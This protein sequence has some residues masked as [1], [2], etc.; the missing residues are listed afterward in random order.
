MKSA[1]ETLSPTRV[2]LIVEV[3]FDELKPDLDAAYQTIGSQIQ[4]P[5]FRK[6]KVPARIIDQR[7]GRGAVVQEAVNEALP[8]FFSQ[9]VDAEGIKAIGQPEVDVTAVPLEDGQ[10]FEFTVETDVRPEIELPE[11]DGIAVEVDE[12]KASD[13]D[14]EERLTSLRQRFGTLTAVERAVEDGDVLSID[15]KAEID[16]D[17]ID[18]VEG[19]TYEVGSGNM[20]DGLDE[21]VLG[22]TAGDSRS[23]SSPLAGGDRE[24]EVA[25]CTVT[26]QSVKVRELPELDDDFAQ[27]A[28]QFDTLD[29][30]REDV[31]KQAEQAKKFEQGVQAR[32]KVLEHLLEVTEVAVPD[33][34]VEAEV[35]S[36][37]EG[38]GRLEDDEH[39]AEV[40]ESTRKALKGQFLL[41]A[42]AEKLEIEV[43]Q[44]ELIEYLIMSAQ[45]YGMDPNQFAQ[46]IDQQGQV[47]SMVQEVARRKALAAVLE[48][49]VVTDTA[50]TT[51]DLNELVPQADVVDP[52]LEDE[53]DL[54]ALADEVETDAEAADEAADAAEE[55]T[56]A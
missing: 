45:Q 21:A 3:P 33:G 37:L 36:H 12:V 14:I 54:E 23:F 47:P 6:G 11:L 17:E 43:E 48:K 26:V 56:K 42:L 32:D 7:V 38:E 44:P 55:P 27:L 4:I 16:G 5:G 9:A 10:D 8:R 30:L 52:E 25:E 19:V 20:L 41:D 1:V 39:R 35:H 46:A 53:A 24:G 18:S 15:L 51:I 31:A 28:S 50:G 34:I 49:A 40:G 2:K 29:E 13:E 22:A